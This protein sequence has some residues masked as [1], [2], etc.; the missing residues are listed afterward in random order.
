M[1]SQRYLPQ[2]SGVPAIKTRY[3]NHAHPGQ[4]LIPGR[5]AVHHAR[6]KLP[7]AKIGANREDRIMT[8]TVDQA[9]AQP[10]RALAGVIGDATSL[11]FVPASHFEGSRGGRLTSRRPRIPVSSHISTGN[12]IHFRGRETPGALASMTLAVLRPPS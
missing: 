4:T 8:E 11:S 1:S 2:N 7:A 3:G 6:G 9:Q 10:L 5:R 12:P